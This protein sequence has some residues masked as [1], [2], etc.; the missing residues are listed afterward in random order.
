MNKFKNK[1]YYL[2]LGTLCFMLGSSNI[3]GNKDFIFAQDLVTDEIEFE[4]RTPKTTKEAEVE[5]LLDEKE[6]Y[7]KKQIKN[8]FEELERKLER[9]KREREEYVKNK[10]LL[11][12]C[13]L[14]VSELKKGIKHSPLNNYAGVFLD[15]EREFGVNAVFLASVAG[16]ESG[17]G[18]SPR[19]KNDNNLFGWGDKKFSSKEEGIYYVA[20]KIKEWYLSPDGKH[21]NGYTIAGVNKKY[22][23]SKKWLEDVTTNYNA[24]LRRAK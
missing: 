4:I 17:W 5:Q 10:P 12:P 14:T 24:I 19:A 1:S 2:V 21:F 3:E 18:N 7:K 22:N 13:G 23:G 16:L 20:E 8:H 11:K 9:E 15:A 6:Q